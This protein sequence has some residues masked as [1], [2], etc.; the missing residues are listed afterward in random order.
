V[1]VAVVVHFRDYARGILPNL[2]TLNPKRDDVGQIQ[3][4]EISGWVE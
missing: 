1:D 3:R 4:A 2:I